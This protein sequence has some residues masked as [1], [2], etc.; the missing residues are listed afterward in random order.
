VVGV[1]GRGKRNTGVKMIIRRQAALELEEY[2]QD[3]WQKSLEVRT[4]VSTASER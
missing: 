2:D 3:E 1:A 4:D